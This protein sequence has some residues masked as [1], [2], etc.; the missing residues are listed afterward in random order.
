M[1]LIVDDKK[2][3]LLSLQSLLSLHGY[4]VDTAGNG[5]EA[6]K[7]VLRNSY[8]LIILDVQMPG[9]DGF[10][11]AEMISGY[12]KTEDIPI[13][14]LSAVN[15]DKKF[16]AKGYSSGAIDY[17]TKP[18]DPDI[19]L[20]KVNTLYKLYE[21]KRELNEMQQTLRNEIEYRK[22]AQ[23]ESQE[24][25]SQL[26]STL[27]SIPQIA[28]TTGTDGH[29]EYANSQWDKYA[30]NG[31]P[32]SHPD[33]PPVNDLLQKMVN[34][35][36][37]LNQELRIKK[38]GTEEYS[39]FLLRV[40]PVRE[41]NN[42]VK[43]VG[44]FTDIDEQK[45]ASRKKDEFISVA[46]HE[47]KTPLTSMK[48]YIQLLQRTI[49][50]GNPTAMYVDRTL[51]QIKKLDTLIA[52]LLD[53]SKI[54]SGKMKLEMK[55]FDLGQMVDNTIDMIHQ[56]YPGYEFIRKGTLKVN[57][58]GDETRLEQVLQNFLS[59]AVKYSPDN[60]KVIIHSEL[61]P[62]HRA[63]IGIQDFGIGISKE[64]QQLVFDKF[65]RTAESSNNF[66]GLGLGLYISADIL[67][68]HN[69]DF[70]VESEPGRGSTFYFS[71][72]YNNHYDE[73]QANS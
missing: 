33:D 32:E 14:F 45:Q 20:L 6:L 5:E 58:L 12:S 67:Q 34:D 72:P 63:K 65:Y 13:I 35:Q 19:F 71:L 7:K 51:H 40:V 21:Q 46:S 39:Y 59:N 10:E 69:A 36:Q 52:D 28:F 42:I 44:T 26:V 53:I 50:P 31:F 66:Q 54:E 43:W 15:T 2:E 62:G 47:L 25:T 49:E 8:A 27:E 4:A 38:P 16:I 11:V 41:G 18:I 3:N 57:V 17:I 68:R 61:L 55:S 56:T 24:K 1:I 70:G 48:G 9:M 23:H 37:P 64:E 60:K 29:I 73:K 22:K 30:R